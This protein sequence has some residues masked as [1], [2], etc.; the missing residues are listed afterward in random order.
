[1]AGLTTRLGSMTLPSPVLTSAGCFAPELSQFLDLSGIGAVTLGPATLEARRRTA[2]AR[3]TE[4]PSGLLV[5]HG[6]GGPGIESVLEQDLASF[7]ELGVRAVVA[8]T[9]QHTDEFVT[10]AHRLHGHPAVRA[11]EL[12][13][14]SAGAGTHRQAINTDPIAAARVVG[15]VRRAADPAQPVFAKLTPDAA[16]LAH[17]ARVCADAGADGFSLISPPLGLHIDSNQHGSVVTGALCGPAIRPLALRCVWQVRLAIPHLPII[18]SGGIR[19]GLDAL[20]FVL[21]GASAVA[22]GSAILAD[23]SAPVRIL[24]ELEQALD[25]HGFSTVSDAVGRAHLPRPVRNQMTGE[26]TR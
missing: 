12:D 18:G 17:M 5:P 3:M 10:L 20:L 14:S 15:A 25:E 24:S 11:I 13:L 2:T 16:D 26:T 9:G 8:I 23:P 4:T 19:T 7:A 22:I 1:M 6:Q 21:A